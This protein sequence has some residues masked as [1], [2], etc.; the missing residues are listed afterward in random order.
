MTKEFFKSRKFR[1][2]IAVLLIIVIGF[3][4][5]ILFEK[6]KNKIKTADK[7]TAVSDSTVI[8][9]NTK[10]NTTGKETE[11]S[12][13]NKDN[14][15][16]SKG[17]TTASNAEKTTKKP[18]KTKVSTTLPASYKK[19]NVKLEGVTQSNQK[20]L[21]DMLLH[22]LDYPFHVK[23]P[24]PSDNWAEYYFE[25][26][27]CY[28][29]NA[30]TYAAEHIFAPLVPLAK[31]MEEWYDWPEKAKRIRPT[32]E[33]FEKDD[34]YI[35]PLKKLYVDTL[36]GY[37][38]AEEKYIDLIFKYVFNQTPNHDYEL[39]DPNGD[40]YAYH[41]DG[42]YYYKTLPGGDGIIPMVLFN[43][44]NKLVDGAYSIN[45]E[46]VYVD[47]DFDT[48]VKHNFAFTVL[49]RPVE[50]ENQVYWTIYKIKKSK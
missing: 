26:F 12:A 48:I 14:K 27:D 21:Q 37:S 30:Y 23:K 47:S 11:T 5:A 34:L 36:E 31:K 46:Y 10:N 44:A 6:N 33:Q 22:I 25:D 8:E 3:G 42:K 13:H 2:I 20:I 45:A 38:I 9:S 1:T 4:S 24:S 19:L 35:D 17:E 49:V 50:Y 28:S 43:S 7:L 16:T 29:Q 39:K 32:R 15:T 18:Q 40:V 41:Y